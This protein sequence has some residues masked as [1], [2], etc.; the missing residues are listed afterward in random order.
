M[1]T[2]HTLP[3]GLAAGWSRAAWGRLLLLRW[4]SFHSR[5][6]LMGRMGCRERRQCWERLLSLC[7]LV[8]T[9]A[10]GPQS[11]EIPKP[12][13][14][15]LGGAHRYLVGCA[16]LCPPKPYRDNAEKTGDPS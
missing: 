14:L 15:V 6:L 4:A 12:S 2:V 7:M 5:M 13:I 1:K 16:S 9:P 8:K 10:A 3:P 11:G